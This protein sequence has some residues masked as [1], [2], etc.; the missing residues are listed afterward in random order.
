M[1]P[2]RSHRLRTSALEIDPPAAR[3]P[4][5]N[6]L[7]IATLASSDF[8]LGRRVARTVFFVTIDERLFLFQPKIPLTSALF[9]LFLVVA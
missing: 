6:V 4:S 8:V 3:G 7:S 2:S 9:Q 5:L 1:L